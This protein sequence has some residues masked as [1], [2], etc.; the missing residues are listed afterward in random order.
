M[1]GI[2]ATAK[3]AQSLANLGRVAARCNEWGIP[4]VA[5]MLPGGFSA[6]ETTIQQIRVSA[7]L[8]A[9][10][11]ADIVKIKYQGPVEEFKTVTCSSYVPVV[12][13]GGSK[14]NPEQLA[15]EVNQALQAGARGVAVGRNIWQAD[16]AGEMAAMLAG[17][18]HAHE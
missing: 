16:R 15:A 7:R 12:V 2:T 1:M 18:V 4:L 8:A 17:V 3:E 9:E 5:E 14:Q 11:G 6:K 13:L 10:L